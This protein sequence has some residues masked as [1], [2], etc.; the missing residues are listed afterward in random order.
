MTFVCI[1]V[2]HSLSH[3]LRAFRPLSWQSLAQVPVPQSKDRWEALEMTACF[4]AP[5]AW[6]LSWPSL[7]S[8]KPRES[9]TW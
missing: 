8:N 3:I 6:I 5:M 7:I 1:G 2:S 4:A 9:L